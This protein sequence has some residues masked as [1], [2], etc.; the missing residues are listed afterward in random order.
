MTT[1]GHIVRQIVRQKAFGETKPISLSGGI[2]ERVGGVNGGGSGRSRSVRFSPARY[3]AHY[4]PVQGGSRGRWASASSVRRPGFEP[5]IHD[6]ASSV[7]PGTPKTRQNP[8]DVEASTVDHLAPSL[9]RLLVP[10]TTDSLV[11]E[12]R[13]VLEGGIGID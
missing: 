8:P 6:W 12:D 13:K 3:R 2:G 5:R 9:L 7:V 4:G 11:L 1:T 10:S